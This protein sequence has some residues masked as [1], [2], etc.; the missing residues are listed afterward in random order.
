MSK[1]RLTLSVD[2]DVIKQLKIVAIKEDTT[3]TAI[4]EKLIIDYLDNKKE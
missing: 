1:G 2:E 4:V 3:V